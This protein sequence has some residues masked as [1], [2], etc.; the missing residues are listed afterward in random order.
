VHN[1]SFEGVLVYVQALPVSIPPSARKFSDLESCEFEMSHASKLALAVASELSSKVT[2]AG[3]SPILRESIAR[4]AASI[5][6]MPLCDDP[7]MQFSFFPKEEYSQFLIGEN[8]DW[9]F[10]GASLAGV[11][12]A[13]TWYKIKAY[14]KTSEISSNEVLIISDLVTEAPAIDIRRIDRSMN[15]TVNPEG[16]L[17][18]ML[19]RKMEEAKPEILTGSIEDSTAVIARRLRRIARG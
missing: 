1:V 12:S 9:V 8:P 16:V 7:L 19:L 18:R 17:G 5:H 4:G 11:I 10:S 2:A 15:A 6:S 3:F 13:K 14:N